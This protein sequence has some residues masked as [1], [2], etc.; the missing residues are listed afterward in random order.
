MVNQNTW[1]VTF[2]VQE[3]LVALALALLV[4]GLALV[5]PAA[6]LLDSLQHQALVGDDYTLV[7]VGY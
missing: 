2:D 1:L 7:S 3:Y 4:G 6:A 5:H